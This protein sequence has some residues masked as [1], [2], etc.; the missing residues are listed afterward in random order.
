MSLS[1]PI[2]E[3]NISAAALLVH[4]KSSAASI[5]G[6]WLGLDDDGIWIVNPYG[7]DAG[8]YESTVE[9]CKLILERIVNYDE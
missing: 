6:W 7:Q 9:D 1:T 2:L 8:L 4:L 3:K 5:D